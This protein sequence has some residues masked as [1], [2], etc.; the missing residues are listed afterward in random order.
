MSRWLLLAMA[1]SIASGPD[2]KTKIDDLLSKTPA[3]SNAF[4]GSGDRTLSGREYPYQY[5]PSGTL[6][7]RG[8][9]W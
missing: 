1:L 2:L 8:R 4:C 7:Y 6:D 9:R 5:H 3:M